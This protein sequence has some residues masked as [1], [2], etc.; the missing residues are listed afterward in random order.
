VRITTCLSVL[1]NVSCRACRVPSL[2]WQIAVFKPDLRTPLK[3][4]RPVFSHHPRDHDLLPF[5][6]RD[7]EGVERKPSWEELFAILAGKET[8]LSDHF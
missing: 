6:F 3:Q 8:V 4:G 5:W 7:A 1:L 2:S